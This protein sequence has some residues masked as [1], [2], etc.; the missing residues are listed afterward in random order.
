MLKLVPLVFLI[1]LF[2]NIHTQEYDEMAHDE[3]I[4]ESQLCGESNF[5]ESECLEKPNCVFIHWHKKSLGETIR[6]CMSYNEIMRYYIKNPTEY[7]HKMGTLSHKS[8]TKSN[9]C[10]VLDEDYQFYEESGSIKQCTVSTV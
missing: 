2:S 1:V 5:Y 9:F 8:I 4:S 3:I 7:L 10:D 6:L